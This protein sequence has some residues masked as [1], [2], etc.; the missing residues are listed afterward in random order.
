MIMNS[1]DNNK[2]APTLKSKIGAIIFG[3][4]NQRRFSIQ[5]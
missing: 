4:Q 3:V 5:P 2:S 1:T